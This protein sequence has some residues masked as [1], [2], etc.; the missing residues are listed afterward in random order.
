MGFI[1]SLE[2]TQIL[3]KKQ[4]RSLYWRIKAAMKKAMRKKNKSQFK[5]QYDPYSYALNF[6]DGFNDVMGEKERG[7]HQVRIQECPERTVWVYV[8][9]SEC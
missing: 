9:L 8:V 2:W 6:D 3:G 1:E 7:F 4:R 5:F